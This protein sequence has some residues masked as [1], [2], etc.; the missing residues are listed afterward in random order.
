MVK[1]VEIPIGV[2]SKIGMNQYIKRRTTETLVFL[3]T[4]RN[5]VIPSFEESVFCE[6]DYPSL[7]N[8]GSLNAFKH[9]DNIMQ[10]MSTYNA[11]NNYV[12]SG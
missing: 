11:P 2:K 9:S 5:A 4:F 12:I 6:I 8:S 3:H 7:Y 10:G 1:S